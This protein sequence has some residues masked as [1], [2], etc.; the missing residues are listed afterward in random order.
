MT[1]F[2]RTDGTFSPFYSHTNLIELELQ[3][4]T[5]RYLKITKLI[6]IITY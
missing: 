3:T 1:P 2:S 4:L 6:I 5:V